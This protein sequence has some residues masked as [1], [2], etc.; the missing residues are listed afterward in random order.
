LQLQNL[1]VRETD[2][3]SIVEKLK[4]Y[5]E[6]TSNEQVLKDW[7]KTKEFDEIGPI[8]DDFLSHTNWHFKIKFEDPI[9]GHNLIINDYSP[10]FS[11]GFFITNI[12]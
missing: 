10:K 5:F 7:E 4:K 12:K 8:M 2:M 11:S 9:I 6:S 1:L 3:E